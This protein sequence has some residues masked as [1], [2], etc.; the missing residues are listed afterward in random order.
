MKQ[1][2]VNLKDGKISDL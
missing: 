2:E 1:N